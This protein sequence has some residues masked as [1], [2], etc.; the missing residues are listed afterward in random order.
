MGEDEEVKGSVVDK[1]SPQNGMLL[2]IKEDIRSMNAKYDKLIEAIKFH[3]GKV[4]DFEAT[5]AKFEQKLKEIDQLKKENSELNDIFTKTSESEFDI[6][7]LTETWLNVS[8]HD[9]EFISRSYNVF[10]KDRSSQDKRDGGGVLIAVGRGVV[11]VARP[12]WSSTV[13]DVWVT[14]SSPRGTSES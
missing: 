12:E 1:S 9:H 3:G 10:R 5:N 11:T 2:E 14:M 13:E 7:C 8:C 6:M 4:S